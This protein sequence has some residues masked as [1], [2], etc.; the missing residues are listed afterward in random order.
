M[1]KLSAQ[2]RTVSMFGPD[3]MNS[4]RRAPDPIRIDD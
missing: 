2:E 1:K 3:V 4:G